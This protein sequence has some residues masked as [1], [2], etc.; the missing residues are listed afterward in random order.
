MSDPLQYRLPDEEEL[1]RALGEI[2][3]TKSLRCPDESSLKSFASGRYI[4]DERFLAPLLHHLADC[5][6]CEEK[7]RRIRLDRPLER[8]LPAP[9]V[10]P[11]H[12]SLWAVVCAVLG[13]AI[14]T[15]LWLWKMQQRAPETA[16]IDLREVTR[17]IEAPPLPPIT[18][19]RHMMQLRILLANETAEDKYQLGIFRPSDQASPVLL[20]SASTVRDSDS[21][22][23]QA[24]FPLQELPSGNYLLGIRQGDSLWSYY[25]FTLH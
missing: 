13:I 23:L 4:G 16:T 7:L 8:S 10:S 12:T 14:V 5:A 11:R 3:T 2:A 22:S 15:T 1:Q 17:G 18:L 20:R 6:D 9:R 24:L 25:S 21:R 19:H